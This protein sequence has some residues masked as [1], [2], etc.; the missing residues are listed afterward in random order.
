MVNFMNFFSPLYI[1]YFDGIM[2]AAWD[3]QMHYGIGYALYKQSFYSPKPTFLGADYGETCLARTEIQTKYHGLW[4][5]LD[6]LRLAQEI[7][8][9]KIINLEI[10]TDSNQIIRQLTEQDK[11]DEYLKHTWSNVYGIVNSYDSVSYKLV[12]PEENKIAR[13]KA[14]E[15]LRHIHRKPEF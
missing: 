3:G 2:K 10:R 6:Q 4:S 8:C 14:H 1:V 12:T 15:A 5:G 13:D 7:D 9:F 11:V